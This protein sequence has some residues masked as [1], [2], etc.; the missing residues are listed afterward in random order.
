MYPIV[1]NYYSR[2]ESIASSGRV[3]ASQGPEFKT[4]VI[5]KH[6]SII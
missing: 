2:A 4:P 3:I 6:Y 5:K 1:K